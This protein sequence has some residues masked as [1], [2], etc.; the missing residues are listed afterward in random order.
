[1]L[2]YCIGGGG[3]AP[4]LYWGGGHYTHPPYRMDNGIHPNI[5]AH[6]IHYVSLNGDNNKKRTRERKKKMQLHN[7]MQYVYSCNH[8]SFNT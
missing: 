8:T 2:L 5:D 3:V 1:M 6:N 7:V 4:L